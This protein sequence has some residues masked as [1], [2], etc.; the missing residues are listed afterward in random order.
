MADAPRGPLGPLHDDRFTTASRLAAVP[1]PASLA[2]LLARDSAETPSN[3]FADL[4]SILT[5]PGVAASV[6][7]SIPGQAPPQIAALAAAAELSQDAAA[8]LDQLDAAARAALWAAWWPRLA[9]HLEAAWALTFTLP[10]R[11]TWLGRGWR[12]AADAAAAATQRLDFL[13]NL[14]QMTDGLDLAPIELVEHG[15]A[16]SLG[17]RFE[18]CLALLLAAVIDR[19]DDDADRVLA[20]LDAACHAPGSAATMGSHVLLAL[21]SSR[22]PAAWAIVTR[23]LAGARGDEG[24]RRSIYELAPRGQAE[25]FAAVLQAVVDHGLER[26][27]ATSEALFGWFGPGVEVT[28]AQELRALL[29]ASAALLADEQ[30]CADALRAGTPIEASLALWAEAHR[31]QQLASAQAAALFDSPDAERRFVALAFLAEAG[32]PHAQ[33]TFARALDDAEPRLIA[34]A[35]QY[36]GQTSETSV[37]VFEP[38]LGVVLRLSRD[39]DAAGACATWHGSERALWSD[40]GVGLVRQLRERP[41][42]LLVEAWPELP[43]EAQRSVVQ[44]TRADL[45]ARPDVRAGLVQLLAIAAGDR[46]PLVLDR[47]AEDGLSPD[48]VPAVEAVVGRLPA[49]ARPEALRLLVGQSDAAALDSARRL[50]AATDKVSRQ[51]GLELLVALHGSGRAVEAC[52]AAAEAFRQRP[53]KILAAEAK[54]LASLQP[55]EEAVGSPADGF[56]LFDLADLV[57]PLEPQRQ[58]A[59]MLT[60]AAVS[61]AQ[62]LVDLLDQRGGEMITF[63]YGDEVR[64]VPL[65]DTSVHSWS[66]LAP[67]PYDE[68]PPEPLPLLDRWRAWY[69]DRPDTQRDADGLELL[70]AYWLLSVVEAREEMR[71]QREWFGWSTWAEVW[72]TAISGGHITVPSKPAHTS[73]WTVVP[74]VLLVEADGDHHAEADLLLAAAEDALAQA[75]PEARTAVRRWYAWRAPSREAVLRPF[76]LASGHAQRWP[77]AW[78]PDLWSRCYRLLRYAGQITVPTEAAEDGGPSSFELPPDLL[79]TLPAWRAGAIGEADV[80]AQMVGPYNPD[81]ASLLRLGTVPQAAWPVGDYPE[82]LPLV[83]RMSDRLLDVELRRGELETPATPYVRQISRLWGAANFA[84]ILHVLRGT[85]LTS[86][87]SAEGPRALFSNLARACRLAPEETV[88]DATALLSAA[89]LPEPLRLT[90]MLACPRWLR[91]LAETLGWPGLASMAAWL[92]A[93]TKET[94]DNDD[95]D[96]WFSAITAE[97]PLAAADLAAGAADLDWFARAYAQLGAARFDQLHAACRGARSAG[98]LSR[99]KLYADTLRGQVTPTALIERIRAKRNQD[100][101]RALGLAPLPAEPAAR[102][103]E[104]L[105]RYEVFTEFERGSRAFGAQRRESEQRAAEI[106]LDNLAR[107]AGYPDPLRLRWKLEAQLVADL[108][109]GPVIATLDDL[110]V[111]LSVDADGQPRLHAERAGK[112]LKNIPAAAG[113][114]EAIAALKARKAALDRT[115]TRLRHALEEAMC[116]GDAF[117]GAEL[118]ELARHPLL[119]PSL[120]RLVWLG[121]GSAGYLVEGGLALRDARGQLQPL[122]A[123]E[124]VRLAHTID[125]LARGDLHLW[126]RDCF[127]AGRV[128]PFKQV[129]R[130]VYP[131]TAAERDE[132]EGTERYRGQQVRSAHAVALLAGRGWINTMED[133]LRRAWHQHR[134]GAWLTFDEYFYAAS[135]LPVLTVRTVSFAT[136]DTFEPLRP[137]DVPPVVF[138][139]A[140][141]DVDLAVSVAHVSGVDPEATASTVELRAALVRETCALLNLGNVVVDGRWA[142]IT[143]TLATYRVHLGA[144]L[145]HLQPGGMLVLVPVSAQ[146]RGRLFLPFADDDPVTAEVLSKVILL[147]RDQDLRDPAL[148]AAIRRQ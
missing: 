17:G 41:F 130:E 104:L 74:A 116:R 1:L 109:A 18:T 24:L 144:G 4:L 126:Q 127:E 21:L 56:G 23:L 110:T 121:D 16:L 52:L 83:R 132:R 47:I 71:D 98:A 93:H 53:A 67:H 65:A 147:A 10:A 9:A 106:A 113:K 134:L 138:S 136:L 3:P 76:N 45:R 66:P 25:A 30:R 59:T 87:R 48:E 8:E 31:D 75:P 57:G 114:T 101:L 118:I 79:V 111:S 36:L 88:A 40:L 38:L 64:T 135:E 37:D 73:W 89:D 129:F 28:D 13:H 33:A 62:S 60:P 112:A 55:R 96:D 84:R 108:A 14:L 20:A 86:E 95:D 105:A 99:A 51:V 94:V 117:T 107:N 100:S 81:H 120:A 131:L 46:L 97:T 54:L 43:D 12:G 29:T 142:T 11:A 5:V 82:L 69:A 122:G 137:A 32:G 148:L 102:E 91:P 22:R 61:L 78:T 42:A 44:A 50:L 34:I 103:A 19:G 68:P 141:R 92:L 140:M 80:L 39:A 58:A 2:R 146:H 72:L 15:V 70:R 124:P 90:A 133:G 27:N 77:A 6:I 128:Q 49:R 123:T 63:R 35:I 143:G 145:V 139:E 26:F 125:L 85:G 7:D 119:A 115:A